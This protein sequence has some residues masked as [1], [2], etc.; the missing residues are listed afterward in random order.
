MRRSE[1]IEFVILILV[2]IFALGF[3]RYSIAESK[4]EEP[5]KNTDNEYIAGIV[6][7]N[8][9][10][11]ETNKILYK[12]LGIAKALLGSRSSLPSDFMEASMLT[13]V[14]PYDLVAIG[15]KESSNNHYWPPGRVKR[16]RS[17]EIGLMQIMPTHAK[18]HGNL[19][20]L[21][22]N[23]IAGAIILKGYI[24]RFGRDA[25]IGAYNGGPGRPNLRYSNTIRWKSEQ[26]KSGERQ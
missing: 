25:G 24:G 12:K 15:W 21:R 5:Q 23:I 14:D 17:G 13:G 3:F 6:E 2:V 11:N 20:N 16:G 4:K 26:F 10:L 9:R 19:F 22:E 18:N 1:K 7:M 8:T